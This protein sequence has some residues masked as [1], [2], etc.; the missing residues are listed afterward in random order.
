MDIAIVFDTTES[1]ALQCLVANIDFD[2]FIGKL[3]VARITQGSVK[4]GQAV[5]LVQPDKAPKN[6][7]IGE[8]YAFDNLGKKKVE[9][10]SAGDVIMFSGIPEVEI[11]DT[12]VSN[13]GGVTPAEPLEPIAVEAPTVKIT[14]GVNKSPLAGREGKF[15]TSR[16]IRE[17]LF[18]ELDKNVALNVE[19][20][21]E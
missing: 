8:L 6:G 12:L 16:M 10:A 19:E 20:V 15:L 5:S 17:R 9:S 14:L 2:S 3:G 13:E 18:K 4:A 21:R 7:R 1:A 11:G